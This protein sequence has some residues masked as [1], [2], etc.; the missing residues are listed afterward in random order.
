MECAR[1]GWR[2]EGVDRL[3]CDSCKERLTMIIQAGLNKEARDRLVDHYKAQLTTT[4]HSN[5]CPWRDNAVPETLIQLPGNSSYDVLYSCD[6]RLSSLHRCQALP[7]IDSNFLQSKEFQ[8]AMEAANWPVRKKIDPALILAACGWEARSISG[9]NEAAPPASQAGE[10]ELGEKQTI[11]FCE[12]DQRSCGLWNFRTKTRRGGRRIFEQEEEGRAKEG[13]HAE[14]I[15]TGKRKKDDQFESEDDIFSDGNKRARIL[16]GY[17][18]ASS[19]ADPTWSAPFG[20]G[21]SSGSASFGFSPLR[22]TVFSVGPKWADKPLGVL[23]QPAPRPREAVQSKGP[24]HPIQQ[25]RAGSQWT[26]GPFPCLPP[27]A[28]PKPTIEASPAWLQC[29]AICLAYM[30]P[31]GR[32]DQGGDATLR[33]KTLDDEAGKDSPRNTNLISKALANLQRWIS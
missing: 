2:N 3:R 26:A 32:R 33:G 22:S 11:L 31:E 29:L 17:T 30:N 21:A 13:E 8:S 9:S 6:K 27:S 20:F 19:G 12:H 14:G 16:G 24:F 28:L 18:S 1:Y 25:H 10:E 23:T 5:V 4:G 15:E 7:D